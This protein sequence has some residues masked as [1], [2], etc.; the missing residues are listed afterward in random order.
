MESSIWLKEGTSDT[1]VKWRQ[2]YGNGSVF[3]STF[4]RDGGRLWWWESVGKADH[5]DAI[6][7]P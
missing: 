5:A 4:V 2:R 7:H 1:M 6:G 3:G